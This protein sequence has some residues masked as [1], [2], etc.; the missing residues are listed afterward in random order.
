[1]NLAVFNSGEKFIEQKFEREEDFEKEVKL[2]YKT[3]FGNNTLYLDTKKKID[4]TS[5]GGAIIDGIL[6]DFQDVE[7]IKFYLIEVELAKHSFYGHIFPQITKFFAFY[8]NASMMNNLIDKIYG[9][10]YPSYGWRE[11]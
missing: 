1:M 3:L 4:T 6:F 10:G 8:K 2:N 11:G 7:D 9:F 5:L